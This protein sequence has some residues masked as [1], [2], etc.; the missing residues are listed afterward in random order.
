M[1]ISDASK[2]SRVPAPIAVQ[3]EMRRRLRAAVASE[4]VPPPIWDQLGSTL[5][6]DQPQSAPSAP[7]FL[8]KASLAKTFIREET[9]LPPDDEF[10]QL[11]THWVDMTTPL[12]ELSSLIL[13]KLAA[14][15]RSAQSLGSIPELPTA[16]SKAPTAS[17]P[18]DLP[19]ADDKV[20]NSVKT[21]TP[22]SASTAR[23]RPAPRQFVEPRYRELRNELL[24]SLKDVEGSIC[25]GLIDVDDE[26]STPQLY[27]G[28]AAALS[29]ADDTSSPVL[30]VDASLVERR[31]SRSFASAN[32]PGL[33][34]HVLEEIRL[35]ELIVPTSLHSISL[36][37]CGT[38][39][40]REL[41]DVSAETWERLFDQLKERFRYI[42]VE[43]SAE[44]TL[45]GTLGPH[46]NAMHLCLRLNR[47]P[48][49]RFNQLALRLRRE[50]VPN[51]G[52][53]L[54]DLPR[55]A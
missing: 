9:Q 24:A 11:M 54:A 2:T 37:P 38:K 50:G 40:P 45:A 13:P 20:I 10:L 31:L 41:R 22:P 46:L 51:L 16:D 30:L 49:A 3:R 6:L 55:A 36:L 52:C 26:E 25:L 32:L 21:E 53:L 18:A 15:R 19:T 27:A 33:G 29:V 48:R 8:R 34:E 42:L 7:N 1:A 12:P 17:E 4:F 44:S 43:F 47:T 14:L 23:P 5:R 39:R 35:D 28:L